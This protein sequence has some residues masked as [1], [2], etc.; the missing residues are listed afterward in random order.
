MTAESLLCPRCGIRFEAE[1]EGAFA[2]CPACGS[3][4]HLGDEEE[5]A[6]QRLVPALDEIAFL[7]RFARWLR[8]REVLAD[9]KEVATRLLWFPFWLLPGDALVP[10][11]PLLASNLGSFHLP[12]GDRVAFRSGPGGSGEVVPASVPPAGIEGDEETRHE[13]R[14]LHVPFREVRFRLWGRDYTVWFDAATGQALDFDLP[15]TSE[16]RLDVT[17]ALLLLVL[18]AA[19]VYGVR[20]LFGGTGAP[21]WAGAVVLAGAGVVFWAVA[22]VVIHLSEPR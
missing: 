18:F 12:A 10:A 7:G 14:L 6:H 13:A 21:W 9:P 5:L 22:R 17:Y 15:P 20:T 3:R 8:N 11:A 19:G 16:R 2:T 1:E 4:L